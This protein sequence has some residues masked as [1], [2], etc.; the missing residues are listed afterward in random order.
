MNTTT[1]FTPRLEPEAR[2]ALLLEAAVKVAHKHGLAATSRN[3][4][5]KAAKVSPA[6]VSSYFS[7]MAGMRK[8]VVEHA[9]EH[10]LLP[11]IASALA[12]GDKT[13][14][15]APAELQHRALASLLPA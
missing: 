5:A 6:L 13:A 15:K 14:R 7:T 9:V 11:I 4:V 10:Q 3:R 2:K 8:A 12:L 1:T